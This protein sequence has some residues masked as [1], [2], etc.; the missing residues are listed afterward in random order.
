VYQIRLK[1]AELSDHPV[2]IS[3]KQGIAVEV[4]IQWKFSDTSFQFQ[5]GDG[6]LPADARFAPA[7]DAKEGKLLLPRV[8]GELAA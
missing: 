8:G 3:A 2:P 5:R 1:R 4:V 7:V 6:F